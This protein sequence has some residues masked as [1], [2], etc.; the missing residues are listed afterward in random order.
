MRL[1]IDFL[2]KRL[3]SLAG[4]GVKTQSA[5][6]LVVYSRSNVSDA[7]SI[8]AISTWMGLTLNGQPFVYVTTCDHHEQGSD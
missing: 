8:P 2:S 7:G 4:R 5:T 6:K 3:L 1:G